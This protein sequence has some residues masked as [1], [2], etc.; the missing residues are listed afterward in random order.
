MRKGSRIFTSLCL[1][2]IAVIF[3]F[4]S[5]ASADLTTGLVAYWPFNGNANDESGNGNNG[6]TYGTTLTPDRFGNPIV[7]TV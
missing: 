4:T 7:L 3:M 1:G 5:I 2:F 6:T